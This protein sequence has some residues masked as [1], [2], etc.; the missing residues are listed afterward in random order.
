M[1][2][3]WGVANPSPLTPVKGSEGG[4]QFLNEPHYPCRQERARGL[5]SAMVYPTSRRLHVCLAAT[6]LAG[7]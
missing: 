4:L 6:R 3:E 2:R 5:L 7:D 1:N